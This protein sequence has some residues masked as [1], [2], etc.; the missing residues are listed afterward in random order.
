MSSNIGDYVVPELEQEQQ[1]A[2]GP[3]LEQEQPS[4]KER[5]GFL[6]SD[7]GPGPVDS[8]MDHPLNF[9]RSAGLAQVIRGLTGLLGSLEYAVVDIAVGLIRWRSDIAPKAN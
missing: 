3:E 1:P 8:Y 5:F 7:T 2:E 9:S 6:L 4:F